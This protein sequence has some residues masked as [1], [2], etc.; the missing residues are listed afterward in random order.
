MTS[1]SRALDR[2]FVAGAGFPGA[3]LSSGS[4]FGPVRAATCG[5]AVD[6]GSL[7]LA[8]LACLVATSATCA[9]C[10]SAL[11]CAAAAT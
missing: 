11:R 8:A 5:L 2:G 9:S 4:G 6:Q 1:T 3:D 7:L 10:R